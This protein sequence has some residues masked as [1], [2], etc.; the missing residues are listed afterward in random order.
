MFHIMPCFA[1]KF[2]TILRFFSEFSHYPH[3]MV[4]FWNIVWGFCFGAVWFYRYMISNRYKRKKFAI[5]NFVSLL[6]LKAT[7]YK[8]NIK[9]L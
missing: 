1:A 8:P 5:A 4:G 3:F 2:H 6:L 9:P 7:V